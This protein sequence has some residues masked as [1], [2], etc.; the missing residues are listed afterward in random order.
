MSCEYLPAN[1]GWR[2][3]PRVVD[4]QTGMLVHTIQRSGFHDK[5]DYVRVLDEKT[6]L[7]SHLSWRRQAETTVLELPMAELNKSLS[8]A[9]LI[10]SQEDVPLP[11][12]TEP[13]TISTTASNASMGEPFPARG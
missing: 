8:E 6:V 1:A 3:G 7:V 12:V 10:A 13:K 4:R 2:I 5:I 11:P 9:R